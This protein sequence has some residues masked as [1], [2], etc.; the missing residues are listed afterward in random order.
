MKK[1]ILLSTMIL[2]LFI[3]F[4]ITPPDVSAETQICPNSSVSCKVTVNHPT[5]GPITVDSEKGRNDPAV[6]ME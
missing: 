2:L 5:Y 4:S 6:K 3:G 1:S